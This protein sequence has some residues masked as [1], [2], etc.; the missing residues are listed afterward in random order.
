MNIQVAVLCDAATEDNGKLNLLGSFDTIYAPQMPAVHP[1]CSV[2]LR[3]TFV[4]GDEGTRKLT[5]SFINA[6]GRSIMQS[7]E[8]P[9]P[10]ALPDDAHFLTRNFIVNI[11]QLKFEEPGLYSVD[12]RLDNLSQASIPLLVKLIERP[13]A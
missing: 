9:V 1:Q 6:D 4:P 11:Q 2:A 8:M 13:V 3:V 10:V 12:V 5:L 7:I